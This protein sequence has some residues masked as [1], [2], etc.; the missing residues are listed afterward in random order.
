MRLEK[1]SLV[2]AKGLRLRRC[3]PSD[4]EP[5]YEAVRESIEEVAPWMAWCHPGYSL[6]DSRTWF[7]SRAEAWERGAEFD[8]VIVDES[9]NSL[10]GICGL[11]HINAEERFANLGYWVRTTR[12]RQGIATA[13]IPLI[14][15]FGFETLNLNR[16]EIVVATGNLPS[17]KVAEKAGAL[18]EGILRQRLVAREQILDAVMFSLVPEDLARQTLRSIDAGCSKGECE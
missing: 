11:N 18:R 15:R 9:D 8:F 13:A 17:Q 1:E 5:V 16:I 10:L 6:D 7:D 2:T 3:R 4:A 12:T 14:A